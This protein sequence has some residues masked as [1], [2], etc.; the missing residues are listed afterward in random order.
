MAVAMTMVIMV[1]IVVMWI[2]CGL[3]RG[4]S[5]TAV[6]IACVIAVKQA[7]ICSSAEAVCVAGL[8]FQSL[9]GRGSIYTT[10]V[11]IVGKWCGM[12]VFRIKA[13]LGLNGRRVDAIFVKA[14]ANGAGQFHVSGRSL[15][16][17]IKVDLDVQA[18]NELGV[19]QLPYVEVMGT[20]NTRKLL[21]VF[22]DI[23]N[24]Q[25][26][27][28][29]LKQDTRGSKAKGDGRG[30]N[31]AGD[32]QG[33]TRIS[34]EAPAVVDRHE[35][36]RGHHYWPVCNS[37]LRQH[38]GNVSRFVSDI[39]IF[40]LGSTAFF[41]IVDGVSVRVTV[42]VGVTAVAVTAMTVVVEEE[43]TDDGFGA[44]PLGEYEL[45]VFWLATLTAQRPTSREMT[46]LSWRRGC[47]SYECY[48]F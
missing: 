48:S 39:S 36:D 9:T 17:E 1:V 33:N 26:S 22:L 11:F 44:L 46:S 32:D 35:S 18:C 3:S 38:I 12:V 20:N 5:T 27:G 43:K 41:G 8:T 40:I 34:I 16:L 30:E 4:R 7:S 15:A 2:L 31:D 42:T 13:E 10:E 21:N 37:A 14:V 47:Q 25:T 45:V 29:S 23:I 6:A 19:A 28:N 24:A